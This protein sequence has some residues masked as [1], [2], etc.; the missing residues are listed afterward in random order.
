[1]TLVSYISVHRNNIVHWYRCI[2][3]CDTR[4]S[5]CISVR[6]NQKCKTKWNCTTFYYNV[7]FFLSQCHI[8]Q[9]VPI[10]W[11]YFKFKTYG[12]SLVKIRFW[13]ELNWL[14]YHL[15][16]KTL[17]SSKKVIL[18]IVLPNYSEYSSK[19]HNVLFDIFFLLS[20]I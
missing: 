16:K 7:F 14:C 6:G 8:S 1:M 18:P 17:L 2:S 13:V 4:K 12:K 9:Y 19:F 20:F 3:R 5:L 11:D 15:E 10:W